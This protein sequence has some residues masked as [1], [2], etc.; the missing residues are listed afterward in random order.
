[1]DS[2]KQRARILMSVLCVRKRGSIV[3]ERQRVIVI[4][5]AVLL[6]GGRYEYFETGQ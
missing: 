4:Q 5:I 3:T 1:M 2:V 6:T